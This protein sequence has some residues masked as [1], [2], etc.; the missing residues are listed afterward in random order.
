MRPVEQAA[1]NLNV[2]I[3]FYFATLLSNYFAPVENM[4]SWTKTFRENQGSKFRVR[5]VPGV[6][7][8]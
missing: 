2:N 3:S 4:Q 5:P 7:K 8:W 1:S 6:G